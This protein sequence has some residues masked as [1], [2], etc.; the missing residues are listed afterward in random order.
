MAS[1]KREVKVDVVVD[2]DKAEAGAKRAEKAI[3][4]VGDEGE[5]SGGRLSSIFGGAKEK[6]GG[7]IDSLGEKFPALG[8]VMEGAGLTGTSVMGAAL[9][10]AAAGAATAI[11]VFVAKSVAGFS[12]LATETEKLSTVSN[13]SAQD[14]SRWIE[15]AGDWGVSADQLTTTFGKLGKAIGS[16]PAVLKEYGIELARTKSGALDMGATMN[17]VLDAISQQADASKKDEMAQKL[18][19]KSY[20]ELAPLIAQ[21][22]TEREKALASVSASKVVTAADIKANHEFKQSLDAIGD[23][24]S[25]TSNAIGKLLLPTVSQ[26]THSISSA[27]KAVSSA[28]DW[29]GR[30]ADRGDDAT[31]STEQLS[32]SAAGLAETHRENARVLADNTV[33]QEKA[34]EA[35]ALADRQVKDLKHSVEVYTKAEADARRSIE[36][37]TRATQDAMGSGRDWNRAQLDIIAAEK[38]VVDKMKASEQQHGKNTKANLE[39]ALAGDELRQK[40]ADAG[41]AYATMQGVTKT[42]TEYI[43]TQ[44]AGL[45]KLK[46]EFPKLAGIIDEYIAKLAAIPKTIVTEVSVDQSGGRGAPGYSTTPKGGPFQSF[47]SLGGGS[48]GG[49]AGGGVTIVFNGV[50]PLVTKADIGA[51]VTEALAAAQRQGGAQLRTSTGLAVVAT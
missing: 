51:L 19:G 34:T 32:T 37:R 45:Q 22:R 2:A 10:A 4:G 41:A 35:Q 15:V 31:A 40:I 16:N 29:L 5:R 14:A 17:N 21:T 50:Q 8:K 11:G 46:D 23:A 42:S 36:D 13:L 6:L 24:G 26:Y 43:P 25:D 48:I 44:I 28:T 18:L 9:P 12:H 30:F 20:A 1:G 33:A 39:A 27:A 49:G 38:D 7:A 47:S 3:A